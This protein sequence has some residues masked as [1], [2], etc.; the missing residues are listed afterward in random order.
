MQIGQIAPGSAQAPAA[1]QLVLTDLD[2]APVALADFAGHPIWVVFWK[3]ACDPCEEE[4]PDV[5]AAY[6][7]HRT[8]GLVVLG[9]DVWD[10]AAAVREYANGDPLD[11][12]IAIAPTSAFLD[13][14]GIWGAPTHYFIDAAGII[15]DRYFGPMSRDLIDESLRKII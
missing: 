15:R 10:T 4:A 13:A 5:A 2:G 3:T 8:D 14:Y 1:P 11:Y 9:I 6:T 12:P 7:A